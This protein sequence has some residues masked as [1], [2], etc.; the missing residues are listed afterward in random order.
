[1]LVNLSGFKEAFLLKLQAT[2]GG[3]LYAKLL[4]RWR[5]L[6]AQPRYFFVSEGF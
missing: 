2:G 1:M 3:K 6:Y 4:Y 5:T